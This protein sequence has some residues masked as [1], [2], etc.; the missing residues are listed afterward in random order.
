M[1][2]LIEN[3][4]RAVNVA[5]INEI[6]MLSDKIGVDIYEAVE[7]AA[8]KPFGF[9]PYFPG[10]GIGGHCIPIDP[11]YLS[12]KS[13]QLDIPM[14]LIDAAHEI[15]SEM[16]KWVVDK[17]SSALLTEGKLLCD[18]DVMILESHIKKY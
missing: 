9:T 11:L 16:P 3:V 10:P 15:N 4:Q 14:R 7:A 6:K 13:R 1:V 17:L 12:W 2:K 5:L 8:T 18:A